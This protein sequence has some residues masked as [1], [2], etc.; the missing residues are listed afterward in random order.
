MN[1]TKGQS[2]Q[3][4]HL[5]N[6]SRTVCNRKTTGINTNEFKDYKWWAEKYTENCCKKCLSRFIEKNNRLKI[7]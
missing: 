4:Q 7:K 5:S 1:I 6:G 3:K 2:T